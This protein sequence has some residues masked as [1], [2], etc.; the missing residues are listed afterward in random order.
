[1]SGSHEVLFLGSPAEIQLRQFLLLRRTAPPTR[2]FAL[3]ECQL[4]E[5]LMA[6]ERDFLAQD[7]LH[8]DLAVEQ[9]TVESQVYH[10]GATFSETY[11]S[12][13]GPVTVV[14]HLYHAADGATLCPLELRTGIIEGA[15]TPLAAEQM[16]LAVAFLPTAQAARLITKFGNMS[17]SRSSLDRLPKALSVRWEAHREAWEQAIRTAEK[18]PE[19]VATLAISLDGVMTPMKNGQRAAKRMNS[20]KR[21]KGPAGYQEAAVATLTVYDADGARLATKKFGRMPEPLK[22]TL[23][24]QLTAE[25]THQHDQLPGATIVKLADGAAENWRILNQIAPEGIA[26]VDYFHACEHLQK[27]FD[28]YYGEGT[29]NAKL[30][31]AYFRKV[32]R[33]K[34]NG[35]GSVIQALR[36][37]LKTCPRSKTKQLQAELTYFCNHRQQMHYAAYRDQGLPIGSGVVEAACKT[38]VTQ[39]LKGSGMR[40]SIAGGQAILTLRSLSQ[41][42]RWEQ[43]W[44]LLR[45]SYV[46]PIQFDTV[47][48]GMLNEQRLCA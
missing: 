3:F 19:E 46:K 12:A 30:F 29:E 9:I 13:A 6:L 20:Q 21:P 41:S 36:Y 22:V 10:R 33:D 43:G 1:M 42:D 27:A 25:F 35:V 18:P 39:R 28:A 24:Q 2:D 40:W 26:I 14:R 45:T 38:L 4:H 23:Q 31:S 32:L 47:K 8:Y 48:G 11:G 37:R 17:P 7:L 15:W 5:H 44:D 16:A 34:D